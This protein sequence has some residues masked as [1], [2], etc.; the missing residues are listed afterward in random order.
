MAKSRPETVDFVSKLLKSNAKMSYGDVVKEGKKQGYHVYP[1][2]M[3]L[4]KNALGMGRP[5]RAGRGPGRPQGSGRGPGRP[6]GASRGPGRPAGSGRAITV[7][8]VRGIERM[9]SDVSAMRA[10]LHEIARL[11]SKF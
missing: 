11:A 1:L 4:A 6:A 3:G 5:K 8:L 2:I 9:H 7:D 10:A